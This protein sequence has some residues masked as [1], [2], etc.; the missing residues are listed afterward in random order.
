MSG[1]GCLLLA[2][3]LVTDAR[4]GEV[5]HAEVTHKAGRYSL[6]LVMR[7]DSDP[8]TVYALVTDYDELQQISRIIV[9]S[10][11]LETQPDGRKRRR[12]IT[13]TCIWFYCFKAIMVEDVV[14]NPDRSIL[15]TIVPAQSDYRYGESVW[16][17]SATEDGTRIHFETTLEPDFWV[18][19]VIGTWILKN[20]MRTEAERT[21]LKIEQ[22]RRHE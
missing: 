13:E 15:T 16:H 1:T 19:P 8:D 5:E 10:R 2:L 17:I 12:L 20:K 11:L 14:E 7:I 9:E 22:L 4:A 6:D 18:P 21:V 3:L